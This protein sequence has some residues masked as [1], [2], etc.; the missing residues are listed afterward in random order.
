MIGHVGA[1]RPVGYDGPALKGSSLCWF[2]AS[3]GVSPVTPKRSI[4]PLEP[5]ESS[6]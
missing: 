4:L 1:E 5:T 2:D 3:R 6:T